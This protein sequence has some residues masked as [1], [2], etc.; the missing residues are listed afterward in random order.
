M[1]A[2]ASQFRIEDQVSFLGQVD[3][4]TRDHYLGDQYQRQDKYA[5]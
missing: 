4:D 1:P 3:P 5:D 2:A